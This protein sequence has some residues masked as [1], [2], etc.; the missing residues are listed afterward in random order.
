MSHPLHPSTNEHKTT[1][2][3]IIGF[4]LSLIFTFIPAYLVMQHIM[5]GRPLLLTILG[6]ALLQLIVQ[7]VFFLHLGR[8]PK[9]F[10]NVVFFFATI[11]A[12]LVV[13]GGS[14]IIINNLHSNMIPFDQ[15]KK[16]INDEGIY[17]IGGAVTGAC[18]GRRPNHVISVK[19]GA[20]DPA[21]TLAN[22]CD[23]VS[24]VNTDKSTVNVI[25]G[26]PTMRHSYAGLTDVVLRKGSNKTITLSQEGTFEFHDSLHPYA[27][28]TFVVIP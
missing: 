9:P 13:V 23:T 6:F 22:K 5:Y 16:L 15:T 21:R 25:F 18:E 14:I 27:I 26:S 4:A 8:G 3:Y 7:V 12:I 19:N 11:G 24:F 28:G 2:S 1:Q 10:Y 20:L 17:Q